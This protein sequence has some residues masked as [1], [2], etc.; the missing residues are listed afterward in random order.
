MP[1]RRAP[2][3]NRPQPP[4]GTPD[5]TQYIG[6]QLDNTIAVSVHHYIGS[7][8]G[9][10]HNNQERGATQST[11]QRLSTSSS[12]YQPSSLPQVSQSSSSQ[13]FSTHPT[14]QSR[15]GQSGGTFSRGGSGPRQNIPLVS[16]TNSG[17]ESTLPATLGAHHQQSQPAWGTSVPAPAATF[18]SSSPTI[19]PHRNDHLTRPLTR[20]T[21]TGLDPHST[22]VPQRSSGPA[23]NTFTPHAMRSTRRQSTA[24]TSSGTSATGASSTVTPHSSSTTSSMSVNQSIHHPSSLGLRR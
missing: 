4:A 21:W 15:S 17:Y 14:S 19:D 8:D 6:A 5:V 7:G 23:H 20:T 22:T 2:F 24:T 13:I 11:S 16:T 18:P 1:K 10:S 12:F 9:S 3:S